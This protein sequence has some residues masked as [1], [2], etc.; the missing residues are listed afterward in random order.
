MARTNRRTSN[1]RLEDA[2]CIVTGASSGLGRRFCL[3]LAREGARVFGIA[4][5]AALLRT[6]EADLG[7]R[8]NRFGVETCDVSDTDAF[9]RVLA[10]IEVDQSRVDLLV[11]CAGIPEPAGTLPQASDE[12]PAG[13]VR[14]TDS[15]QDALNA[16]R[17]V[18]DTNFLSAVAGTLQ[19]LPGMLRRDHGVI[20]NVSS[21]S[22][23]APGPDEPAYCAS[24]AALSAFTES[25]ALSLFGGNVYLHVLYPGWV[26]TAM[27]LGSVESGMELP[28]R[29]V[30]RSPEKVSHLLIDRIGTPRMDIDAAVAARFAPA[31]R[32]LAPGAYRR[33]VLRTSG[34]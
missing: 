8:S 15:V 3:D 10:Q 13:A 18:M 16:Y 14:N 22:G 19:V 2:V 17:Y 23:R 29:F 26:P 5:R 11:N 30:R 33:G 27:G 20:V 24:K 9:V 21:D 4:R 6:L 31:A 1:F 34:H 12:T 7:S 32:S 28:P 25:L